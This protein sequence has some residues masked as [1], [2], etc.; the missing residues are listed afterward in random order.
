MV[1]KP[2]INKSED[3]DADQYSLME[4]EDGVLCCSCGRALIKLDEETYQCP[5]GYP[6]YRIADG[7]II[8]DKFGNLMFKAEENHG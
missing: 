5:G 8:I 1:V 3:E 2:D 4:N 7:S 6:T